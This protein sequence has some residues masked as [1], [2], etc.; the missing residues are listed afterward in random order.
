MKYKQGPHT[1]LVCEKAPKHLSPSVAAKGGVIGAV[2]VVNT[3]RNEPR[4][5]GAERPAAPLSLSSYLF[6]IEK[7]LPRR[8]LKASESP[9]APKR[10]GN[11]KDLPR[12]SAEGIGKSLRAKA[13]RAWK[14]SSAQSAEG[15]KSPSAPKGQGHVKDLSR[16][17]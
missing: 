15:I 9:S 5:R 13:P 7:D 16:E 17:S 2:C 14:I 8:A 1:N 10:Q 12:R 6:S 11:R 4:A 3:S